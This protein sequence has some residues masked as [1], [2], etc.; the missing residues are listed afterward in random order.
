MR[1]IYKESLIVDDVQTIRVPKGAKILKVGLQKGHICVWYE[2]E[3]DNQYEDRKIYMFGTGRNITRQD[4]AVMTYNALKPKN[5]E[6]EYE[7]ADNDDISD[8]A[9]QSVFELAALNVIN[10]FD[11]NSFRPRQTATRAQA[12]KIICSVLDLVLYG[13]VQ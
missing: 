10:G 7:F 9:I 2:C 11:D 1:T 4:M 6:A 12:A 13:R 5:T 3:T 8:Y